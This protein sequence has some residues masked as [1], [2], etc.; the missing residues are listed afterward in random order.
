MVLKS[1]NKQDIDQAQ[2]AYWWQ[3]TPLERLAAA[4]QLMAEARRV[5][6]ANPAN[7]PLAYGNRVLKS[8]TPVPRR[9][10]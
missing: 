3:K 7:P 4:A 1:R 5:Y 6:A 8:A 2:R 9:A 10:R